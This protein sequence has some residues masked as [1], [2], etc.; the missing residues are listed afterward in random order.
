MR[1]RFGGAFVIPRYAQP[2]GTRWGERDEWCHGS[3]DSLSP[4]ATGMKH[5]PPAGG[6][7]HS[8]VRRQ[9]LSAELWIY[10]VDGPFCRATMSRCGQRS[11][12]LPRRL[13]SLQL[14]RAATCR[15]SVN[16]R[17]SSEWPA[18]STAER[19]SGSQRI[20]SLE[21][22]ACWPEYPP[23]LSAASHS[24]SPTRKAR[25]CPEPRSIPS[26]ELIRRRAWRWSRHQ[27]ISRCCTTPPR[28]NPEQLSW[29]SPASTVGKLTGS[30]CDW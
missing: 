19:P 20:G 9:R 5:P 27:L 6:A 21:R 13:S 4:Q 24:R 11:R 10:V 22:S 2:E 25:S 15:C 16:T 28:C 29:R 8:P 12:R 26:S 3:T 30:A 18:S 17:R 7:P 23:L 14:R 1:P